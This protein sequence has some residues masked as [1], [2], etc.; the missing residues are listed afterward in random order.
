[1]R[2]LKLV[3]VAA[4]TLVVAGAG[5]ARAVSGS[6]APDG[7]GQVSHFDL[8]RKD[9]LGTARN[10]GSKVWYTV[11][12]GVLS[13][14]YYPTADTTNGET[15]Q[16]VVTNGSTVTDLQTRDMS[17]TVRALDPGGM[18]CRVTT[19]AKSGAYRIETDYL[20]DPARAT[21]LMR[22]TYTPLVPAAGGYRLYVHFDPTL[23]GN[24]GGGAGNGGPDSGTVDTS[25]GH[26]VLVSS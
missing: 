21:V 3:V 14:V 18:E 17:Y 12:N 5:S 26:S 9:C 24:G 7:P 2:R 23:N 25:T 8:A 20:T 22:T 6:A 11:A 13:D 1:M 15:L 10:T 19:T 16:Y 4:L